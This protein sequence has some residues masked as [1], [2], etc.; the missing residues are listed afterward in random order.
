M[1]NLMRWISRSVFR[2]PAHDEPAAMGSFEYIDAA[3]L[4]AADFRASATMRLDGPTLLDFSETL[5]AIAPP[6]VPPDEITVPIVNLA[7]AA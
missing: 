5:P 6:A 4:G 7:R 3:T 1:T 2:T